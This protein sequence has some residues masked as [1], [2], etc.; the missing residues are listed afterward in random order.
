MS[1]AYPAADLTGKVAVVTGGGKGIGRAI[2]E[3]LADAGADVAIVARR[4][5]LLEDAVRAVEAKG[6]RANAYS[7]DLRKLD[8]IRQIVPT[9]SRGRSRWRTGRRRNWS[10]SPAASRGTSSASSASAA[11]LTRSRS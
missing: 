2:V 4:L 7:V 5:P 10:P 8:E 3:A 1:S 9:C 11:S 6:R